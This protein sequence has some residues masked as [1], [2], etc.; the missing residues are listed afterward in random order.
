MFRAAILP[1]LAAA[2]W[3]SF[4]EFLRNEL[5][6]KHLWI[7]HYAGLGLTFPSEMAN[8]MVWGL[9]S[10]ALAISMK[11]ILSRFNLIEGALIAWFMAFVLMWLVT[12]NMA[13]LPMSILPYAIPLSLLEVFVAAWLIVRLSPAKDR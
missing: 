9:W 1:V 3:I 12:G 8:N 4:S 10:L 6:F 13:V 11:A 7:E 2:I 5:L